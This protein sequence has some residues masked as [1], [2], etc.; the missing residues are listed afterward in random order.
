MELIGE[1]TEQV[2]RTSVWAGIDSEALTETVER[3]ATAFA[4][5]QRT[6]R[7]IIRDLWNYID[8]IKKFIDGN[9]TTIDIRPERKGWRI[10]RKIIRDHQVL[11][12]RP[13]MIYIRSEI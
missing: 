3:M 10:P 9:N 1:Q 8:Q 12:R 6:L 2:T 4:E 11:D 13:M 7:K 5:A